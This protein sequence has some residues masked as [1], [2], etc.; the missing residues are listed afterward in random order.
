MALE[1][2]YNKQHYAVLP[3]NF[4]ENEE[5][6]DKLRRYTKMRMRLGH[7]PRRSRGCS[8]WFQTCIQQKITGRLHNENEPGR[9]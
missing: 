4:V 9:L 3:C 2:K 6:C 1:T 5:L 7:T 8:W